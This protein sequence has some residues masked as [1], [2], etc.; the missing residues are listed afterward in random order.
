MPSRAAIIR[1]AIYDR[2]SLMTGNVDGKRFRHLQKEPLPQFQPDQY[3][4][5]AIYIL[6]SESLPDGQGNEGTI[7]FISDDT[8]AL[9]IGRKGGG[10]DAARALADDD[11]DAI[12]ETLLT[13]AEFTRLEPDAFFESIERI[14]RTRVDPQEGDSYYSFVRLAF[15]FR[16]REEFLPSIVD[17]YR[18]AT[19]R[20][21]P[22]DPGSMPEG[23]FHWDEPND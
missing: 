7:R 6:R 8:I 11:A 4:A 12:I 17:P 23:E 13:D 15:T 3:P 1:D 2:V 22:L 19:V 9:A 14:E 18:G 21:R 5:A 16:S 10:L 20:V